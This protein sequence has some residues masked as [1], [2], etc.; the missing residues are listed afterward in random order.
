MLVSTKGRYALRFMAE[1]A[2]RGDKDYVPLKD[3]SDSQ[4][5]SLKY[6]EGIAADLK[7]AGYISGRHGKGGGFKL[8]IS[9]DKCTVKQILTVTEGSLSPVACLK[10]SDGCERAA[11]CKTLPMWKKLYETIDEFFDGITLSELA[12]NPNNKK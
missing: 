3:V 12:N 7:N 6:L 2:Q 5:I 10:A 11:E 4:N 9:S 1:L 8:A